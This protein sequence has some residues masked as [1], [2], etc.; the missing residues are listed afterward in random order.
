MARTAVLVLL[1][2]FSLS[3]AELIDLNSYTF[4]AT[5]SS[6]I[7][8]GDDYQLYWNIN[9]TGDPLTSTVSF[10]VRVRTTGWV[11]LGVSPTGGMAGSDVVIGWVNDQGDHFLHV[12]TRTSTRVTSLFR[13]K[14]PARNGRDVEYVYVY[15]LIYVVS[16]F[17]RD[18]PYVKSYTL[19]CPP[20]NIDIP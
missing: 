8:Q 7:G 6:E 17:Q 10:A 1:G 14:R 16:W 15:S 2:L 13:A 3:L 9:R 18:Q 20:G 12:R 11:G 4:S 19:P 5:L